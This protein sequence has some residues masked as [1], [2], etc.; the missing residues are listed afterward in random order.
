MLRAVLLLGLPQFLAWDQ[1]HQV[2]S[3][4][5]DSRELVR[6]VSASLLVQVAA[7][8]SYTPLKVPCQPPLW[9]VQPESLR[10]ATK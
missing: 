9:V 3:L 4:A 2:I 8:P 6:S 7:S 5:S 1:Y 10:L